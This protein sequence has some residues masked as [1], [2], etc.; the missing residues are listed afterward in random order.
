MESDLNPMT[1]ATSIVELRRIVL[2]RIAE[3]ETERSKEL[4][5]ADLLGVLLA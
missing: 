2:N 1:D 3:L 5:R 4:E